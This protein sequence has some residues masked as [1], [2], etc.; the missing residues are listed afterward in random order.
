M[1]QQRYE[2]ALGRFPNLR[3]LQQIASPSRCVGS[4]QYPWAVLEAASSGFIALACALD[5]SRA[6]LR[7][8]FSDK[9]QAFEEHML[10]KAHPI[11]V[12]QDPCTEAHGVVYYL[13]DVIRFSQRR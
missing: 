10:M 3:A 12:G 4:A 11:C 13:P 5:Y 2:L 7:E 9:Y 6:Q 1:S 8:R